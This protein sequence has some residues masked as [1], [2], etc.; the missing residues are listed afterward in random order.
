MS[1]ESVPAMIWNAT[2]T[3]RSAIRVAA[4]PVIDLCA[5][6]NATGGKD[7]FRI[8]KVARGSRDLVNALAADTE[9]LGDLCCAYEV[10]SHAA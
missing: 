6:P 5:K 8:R 9:H 3:A 2:W 1:I 7:N 10:V 4:N